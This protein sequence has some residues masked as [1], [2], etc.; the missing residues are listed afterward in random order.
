MQAPRPGALR[1]AA[2]LLLALLLAAPATPALAAPASAQEPRHPPPDLLA[3]G[4]FI[5]NST[6]AALRI[7]SM[8]EELGG[9]LD[10][11]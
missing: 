6:Q 2:T 1:L 5:V 3:E 9:I 11:M 8:V 10:E 7:A 4:Q